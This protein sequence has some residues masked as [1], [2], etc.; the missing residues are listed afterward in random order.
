M[1][2][3]ENWGAFVFPKWTN[4]L[5]P[6][7]AAT[8]VL[9][10]AYV[11]VLLAYGASPRTTNVGYRPVQP[12]PYSHALHAG[13]LGIDCR[14]CHNTV[15]VAAHAALPPTQT[16]MN[17]HARIRSTSPKLLVV[18]E[19]YATGLPIPWVR[20][21]DLPDYVYFNHSAHVRRGVGCVECHGRVDT[22]DVVTQ[23]HRLS[24]G[25]C[26]DCHRHPEPHLRPPDMVT[27]MDWV[28]PEDPDVYGKTLRQAN[29][30]NPPTDCWTCHR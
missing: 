5:R 24:M 26:L 23:V 6:V 27:K 7:L 20:V 15:E 30:I 21:H 8:L 28:A 1:K 2:R 22:M 19:S 9:V 12:V 4:L 11:V 25:W 14:Y 29:N 17:C 10:P 18:R 13:Q 3:G 16:C